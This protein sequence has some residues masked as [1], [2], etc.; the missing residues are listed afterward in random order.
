V[1]LAQ[2]NVALADFRLRMQGDPIISIGGLAFPVT[3]HMYGGSKRGHANASAV[4]LAYLYLCDA[5]PSPPHT[6]ADNVSPF[7][8][9]GDWLR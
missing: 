1:S 4:V 5:I 7:S 9:C 3:I 8:A 2:W 6:L